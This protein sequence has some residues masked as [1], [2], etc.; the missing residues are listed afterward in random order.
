LQRGIEAEGGLSVKG[1]RILQSIV[2]IAACVYL[3]AKLG[4]LY[5]GLGLMVALLAFLSGLYITL[6]VVVGVVWPV[7]VAAF[8]VYVTRESSRAAADAPARTSAPPAK[9]NG[10]GIEDPK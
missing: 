4:T 6:A 1:R 2:G 7:L 5:V 9:P 10:L 3:A 8:V